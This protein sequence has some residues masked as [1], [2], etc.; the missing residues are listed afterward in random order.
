M[1]SDKARRI[2]FDALFA[3]L[4]LMFTFVEIKLPVSAAIP[5]PGFR[6]G[7]ANIA[8]MAAAYSFSFADAAFTAILKIMLS[9]LLFSNPVSFLFS[10]AGTLLSLAV[11]ALFCT[12]IG[13]HFSLV[14]I[15]AA[16]AVFH[17]AGQLAVSFAFFGRA[18]L[19][20]AVYLIPVSLISG[21]ATGAVMELMTPIFDRLHIE[22]NERT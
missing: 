12:G 6:L 11:L 2:A 21:I 4:A 22:K 16:C 10:A 17:T 14:G 19:L 20:C 15:S 3:A 7:L 1:H 13:K 9:S 8:V 5:T 18:S